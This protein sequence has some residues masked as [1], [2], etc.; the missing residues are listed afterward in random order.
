MSLPQGA[1]TNPSA[2]KNLEASPTEPSWDFFAITPHA[3]NPL[4]VRPRAIYVGSAG[5][6][7][8]KSQAG[9]TVTFVGV[10]AGTILDISPTHVVDT[11]TAGNLV[12]L[13]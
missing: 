10:L 5:N 3:T 12:G 6:L 1:T 9:T 13:L 11:S 8:V 4:A 2:Y 7:V